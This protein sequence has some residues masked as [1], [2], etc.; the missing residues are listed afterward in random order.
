MWV[1]TQEIDG[2]AVTRVTYG[3]VPEGYTSQQ[4]PLPL[5]PGCYQAYATTGGR[6]EF[7]VLEDKSVQEVASNVRWN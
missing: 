1:L 3:E 6:V 5:H 7:H 4:G 2:P